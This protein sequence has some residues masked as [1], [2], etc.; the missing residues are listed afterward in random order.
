LTSLG[1]ILLKHVDARTGRR[2]ALVE[3]FGQDRKV[4]LSWDYKEEQLRAEFLNPFFE[5]LGPNL[6]KRGAHRERFRQAA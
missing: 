5:S 3:R 2:Q 1:H 6:G 4:F